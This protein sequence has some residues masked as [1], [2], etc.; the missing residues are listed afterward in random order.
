M[1]TTSKI[2]TGTKSICAV[3]GVTAYGMK[4]GKYGLA[5]IRASGTAAGVFY[6]ILG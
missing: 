2:K 4:E 5:L 6:T 1:K 3:K